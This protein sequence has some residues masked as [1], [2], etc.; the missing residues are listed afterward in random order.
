MRT[1]LICILLLQTSVGQ[2]SFDPNSRRY[3][4]Y[5][6]LMNSMNAIFFGNEN[7]KNYLSSDCKS[8]TENNKA[9]LGYNNPGT[10]EAIVSSPNSGYI[11]W[12]G[13]CVSEYIAA[14]YSQDLGNL[15]LLSEESLKY[16]KTSYGLPSISL[17]TLYSVQ[18]N[19]L[20]EDIQADIVDHAFYLV[21]GPDESFNQ[22]GL[23][24]AKVFKMKIKSHLQKNNF[25]LP[26]AIETMMFNYL[27]RDEFLSY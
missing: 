12:I 15:Q 21:H 27:M 6:D 23:L 20:P 14:I 1:F 13:N 26:A 16:F 17:N 8:I 7:L 4:S 2:A 5:Y 25:F 9:D 10:G 24:D 18:F 3:M 11:R 22:F 19:S